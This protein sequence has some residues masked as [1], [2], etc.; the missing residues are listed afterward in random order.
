MGKKINALLGGLVATMALGAAVAL[1]AP[2]MAVETKADV[3]SGTITIDMLDSYWAN[4]WQCN[5]SVYFFNDTTNGWGDMVYAEKGTSFAEISYSLSF[6]PTKMIAVRLDSAA[7]SPTWDKKWNQTKNL[8][9]IKN[10]NIVIDGNNDTNGFVGYAHIDGKSA[11]TKWAW[12]ESM[13]TLSNVKVNG[14]GHTEYYLTKTFTQ[15]EEFGIRLTS[16]DWFAYDKVVFDS[17]VDTSEW[18]S[19]D[20]SANGN[21]QYTGAT[22]KEFSIYFDR[23]GSQIYIT[24]PSYSLA[25]EWAQTFL[26]GLHC[27]DGVT[28]PSASEWN[29]L[30]GTYNLL[31]N[32]VKTILK[33]ATGEEETYYGAAIARYDYVLAKYGT[34]TEQGGYSNFMERTVKTM[35]GAQVN[36]VT[37][38]HA[39]KN[40][41]TLVIIILS[42]AAITALGAYLFID[43]KRSHK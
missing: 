29:A 24:D 25:D 35:S 13:A 1:N 2:K 9:Y 11:E 14:A 26:S 32:G 3:E 12:T 10:G 5:L 31:S 38:D 27:D 30:A 4:D 15:W 39:T 17:S 23:A 6:V 18:K 16:S 7:T 28:A 37:F 19:A 36:P 43:K 34:D 21:I 8:D 42:V 20:G 33:G 41:I 22:A 40:N